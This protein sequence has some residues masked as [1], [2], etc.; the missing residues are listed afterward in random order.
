MTVSKDEIRNIAKLARLELND[1]D[2]SELES[3]FNEII[4][5]MSSLNNLDLSDVEPMM[6]VDDTI[7]PL[8]QDTIGASTPQEKAF[9]NA[10]AINMNH[11]SIP[12]TVQ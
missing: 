6:A 1:S 10:P 12:K 7:K 9:K 2:W 3:S 4:A 8:R 11:F 5:Y